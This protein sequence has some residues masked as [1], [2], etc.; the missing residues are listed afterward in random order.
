[1]DEFLSCIRSKMKFIRK[2]HKLIQP[3]VAELFGI[4][5]DC[6]AKYETCVCP[7]LYFLFSFCKYFNVSLDD[8]LDPEVSLE[9]FKEKY[10]IS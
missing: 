5:R 10:K 4:T 8:F 6:L 2:Q 9:D 3:R 1:M 7:S